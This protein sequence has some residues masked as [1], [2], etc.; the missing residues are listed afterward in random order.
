MHTLHL[1]NGMHNEYTRPVGSERTQP[2]R[3]DSLYYAR[4]WRTSDLIKLWKLCSVERAGISCM[5]VQSAHKVHMLLGNKL[6]EAERIKPARSFPYTIYSKERYVRRRAASDLLRVCRKLSFCDKIVLFASN[7]NNTQI[8]K[9]RS[10]KWREQSQ[11]RHGCGWKDTVC[12]RDGSRSDQW[13]ALVSTV[14][15][16]RVPQN[17]WN[18]FSGSATVSFSRRTHL[19]RVRVTDRAQTVRNN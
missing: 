16:L 6:Y 7:F 10:V 2:M 14:M 13:R 18:L 12:G 8:K 17:N 1:R 15:N 11:Q 4:V 5:Y 9:E 19:S 3:T